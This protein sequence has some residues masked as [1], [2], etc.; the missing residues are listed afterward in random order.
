MLPMTRETLAQVGVVTVKYA[1]G[2]LSLLAVDETGKLQPINF[3]TVDAPLETLRHFAT[4]YLAPRGTT[5]LVLQMLEVMTGRPFMI[6]DLVEGSPHER[7]VRQDLVG[8]LN[9]PVP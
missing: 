6:E 7:H 4:R 3:G 9:H 8:K 5:Q 1:D 2:S